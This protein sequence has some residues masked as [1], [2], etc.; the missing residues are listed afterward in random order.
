MKPRWLRVVLRAL[1]GTCPHIWRP[2]RT[3]RGPARYC[4]LC[5]LVESLTVEQFYS[6]FGRMPFF[7]P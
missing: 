3:S 5:E 1:T 6:H 2:A 4:D 7:H